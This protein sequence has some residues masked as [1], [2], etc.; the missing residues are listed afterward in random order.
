[1]KRFGRIFILSGVAALIVFTLGGC[2][3]FLKHFSYQGYNGDY[4]ALYAEAINSVLGVFGYHDSSSLA[5]PEIEILETDKYGRVMYKYK[6]DCAKAV[7]IVQKYDDD[8][9]Y[10]YPDYNFIGGA[11]NDMRELE[12][13]L[14]APESIENLKAL[15]DFDKEFDESK[16]IKT[17]IISR[18]DSPK[19]SKNT[20]NQLETL[21]KQYAKD[22]GCKGEDSVYKYA[23]FCTYDTYGRML[24]YVNGIHHDVNGEGTNAN[25]TI[26]NFNFAIIFNPDWSFDKTD[27]LLEISDGFYQTALKE[28]KQLHNWNQPLR[29]A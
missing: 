10:Y 19:I 18:K 20:E 4:P 13:K 3:N 25:S 23:I 26:R 27:T 17:A 15:N 22:S 7:C 28:F 12:L 2:T 1:M 14:F 9:V 29:S 5:D 21:C 24:Y 8:Y 16:C 6:E 11:T